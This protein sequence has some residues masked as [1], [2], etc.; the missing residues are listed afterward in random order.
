MEE[1]ADFSRRIQIEAESTAFHIIK[2][3]QKRVNARSNTRSNRDM[4]DRR[5]AHVNPQTAG[6][7]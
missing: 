1:S 4:V 2:N 3:K 7:N 6:T 5:T